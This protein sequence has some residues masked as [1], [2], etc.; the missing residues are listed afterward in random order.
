M[1][2]NQVNRPVQQSE[3]DRAMLSRRSILRVGGFGALA[4]SAAP[5][6]AACS[7]SKSSSSASTTASAATSA[8]AGSSA[9]GSSAAAVAAGT[10]GTV[11]IQLSWIKN[12]EFAGEYFADQKG[13]Y[14]DAGF[15]SVTLTA[16]GSAGTSAE[17][18]VASGK[19]FVGL[20][21]PNI[22]APA[23][24]QGAKLKTVAST[25]QKNPFCILSV[26]KNPIPD[27]ASMK[28]KKIGVQAGGNTTIFKGLLAA[29][30]IDPSDV[31]IVPVQ[32]D[33]TVVTT[34]EVDG[35]M[36]YITNEPLLLEAKGFKVTTFLFADY[37]LSFVA[38]T[39]VVSED[40][41]AKDRAKLKALLVAEIKGWTDAVASPTQSATY[42][43][44]NYGKDQNLAQA[45]QV[46]EATAQ[47]GLIVSADSIKNGLFTISDELIAANITALA[48]TGVK[49]TADQL[50]DMSVLKE[51][52]AE[53]P[54]LVAP[55][56]SAAASVSPSP[57]AS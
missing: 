55:F 6:L 44:T 39:Y 54:G 1:P 30:K 29:N 41:I 17:S 56:A 12:I 4:L 3:T 28:G 46:Q 25:Y 40:T 20:S 15:S 38:E 43:V 52:Y 9:A 10:Y 22:T 42:A 31:T 24:L 14:K 49:I 57:A 53:N 16:G 7:S 35:Y 33:P 8:A 27:V 21:A 19:A 50:F 34:G 45:E 13:Y 32:Y 47:N 11:G 26:A 5:L 51:V 18:A 36:A 23:I 2:H 48:L 37:G